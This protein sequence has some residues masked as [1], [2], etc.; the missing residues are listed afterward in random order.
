MVSVNEA[1]VLGFDAILG[2]LAD[3]IRTNVSL[4]TPESGF[5]R[6]VYEIAEEDGPLAAD[7][8]AISEET[9]PQGQAPMLAAVG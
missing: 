5:C 1:V 2:A 8:Q 9:L 6:F 4:L 7:D 3:F